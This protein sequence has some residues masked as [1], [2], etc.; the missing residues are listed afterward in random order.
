MSVKPEFGSILRIVWD[1][2]QTFNSWSE[3]T[4]RIITNFWSSSYQNFLMRTLN[5]KNSSNRYHKFALINCEF[6]YITSNCK[7]FSQ[8]L[9]PKK[10]GSAFNQ[11]LRISIVSEAWRVYV[12]PIHAY[13]NLLNM[14][15]SRRRILFSY[16]WL[17]LFQINIHFWIYS[18]TNN[19]TT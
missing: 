11:P 10:I 9:N 12:T 19:I 3:S 2:I 1:M 14:E 17:T 5:S 6:T 13:F 7:F 16:N 18:Y 15:F 4:A 8:S